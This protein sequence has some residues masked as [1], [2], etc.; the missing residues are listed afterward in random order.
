MLLIA[1]GTAAICLWW[2]EWYISS[3]EYCVSL[4]WVVECEVG[5]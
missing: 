4:S 1:I 3:P 5:C 2:D